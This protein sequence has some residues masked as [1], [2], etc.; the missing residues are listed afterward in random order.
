MSFCSKNYGQVT[1]PAVPWQGASFL[2]IPPFVQESWQT[3]ETA[4]SSCETEPVNDNGTLF[5]IN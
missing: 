5:G 3:I 4:R 1:T 2:A